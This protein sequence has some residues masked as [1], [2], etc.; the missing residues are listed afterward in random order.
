MSRQDQEHQIPGCFFLATATLL[1]RGVRI[2][3]LGIRR[4]LWR[5]AVVVNG[6]SRLPHGSTRRVCR[7]H[8]GV[9]WRSGT[10]S[11]SNMPGDRSWGCQDGLFSFLPFDA[12]AQN[13][14]LPMVFEGFR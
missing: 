11:V 7:V 8:G 9:V 1:G 12:R 13:L 5:H 4:S 14:V 3:L 2:L 6:F 10:Q